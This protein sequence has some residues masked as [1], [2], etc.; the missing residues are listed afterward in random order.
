MEFALLAVRLFLALVFGI[1]A[2]AK[3][4]DREGSRRAARAFGVPE[5]LVGVTVWALPLVEM[6]IALALIPLSTAW[7]GAIAALALLAVFMV[8]IGVMLARGQSADCHCFGQL[9]SK[10]VSWTTLARNLAFAG[11]AVFVVLGGRDNAGL[12]AVGWL[13]EMRASEAITLAL[14]VA[15]TLL[16][17][18][19][20]MFL[21]R[22]I[23]QQARLV[24][25]VESLKALLVEEGEPAPVLRNDAAFPAEGLPV[26][27]LAPRFALATIAGDSVSL[28]DLVGRGKMVLLLFVG[29]NC[30]GCKLLLP[31]VRVWQ[32]DYSD[33][34][35]IAVLSKST[36]EE[37]EAKMARY[38]IENLLLDE[39]AEVADDY[40]TAWTP[41]AVLI[42]PSGKI[43]S[44][45]V[46]GDNAIRSWLRN[47]VASDQLQAARSNGASAHRPQLSIRYSV[48]EIGEPAPMFSLK[49]LNGQ[50]VTSED[51]MGRPALLLFW[52]AL[53]EY[54]KAMHDD[55]RRWEE[56]PPPDAPR[57]VFIAAGEVDDIREANK[58][59][60]SSTL[61]DPEFDT[62]PLFGTKVTPSAILIDSEGRIASSLAMEYN[63]VRA[64]I[65]LQKAKFELMA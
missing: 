22:L 3:I 34:L 17:A 2:V 6:L 50:T 13:N 12:S 10:P 25:D 23:K 35:T 52:H 47:L 19:T 31:A 57:L 24:G 41:A 51:L 48:R 60:I 45:I 36:L 38:E 39:R 4:A 63:K 16:L 15:A 59:F 40:E 56:D 27:A 58:D 43:A 28:D 30:W 5:R 54:C 18:V 11:A 26:G 32:R 55:L 53:C 33:L 8:G 9:H 37:T 14:A 44:S 7:W 42:H 61:L 29:P 49:D 65:G 20:I 46:Y 21:R 62:A 1:A 64:L